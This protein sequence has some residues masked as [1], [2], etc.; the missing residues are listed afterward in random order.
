MDRYF[1]RDICIFLTYVWAVWWGRFIERESHTEHIS[2]LELSH[3]CNCPS[4]EDGDPP[5]TMTPPPPHTYTPPLSYGQPPPPTDTK[6]TVPEYQCSARTGARA[7][8]LKV[9]WVGVDGEAHAL[10]HR[11]NFVAIIK[12]LLMMVEMDA[13]PSRRDIMY[14]LLQI[15][16]ENAKHFDNH[17]HTWDG[18][19]RGG[20]QW[21]EQAADLQA[22]GFQREAVLACLEAT[23]GNVEQA[24]ACIL[25]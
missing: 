15:W 2:S 22:M 17:A 8:M 6:T 18:V 20:G 19:S 11:Q 3:I 14:H 1:V 7:M 23:Q 10:L 16:D 12:S 9:R 5:L 13:P 4:V 25:H 21:A 24:I